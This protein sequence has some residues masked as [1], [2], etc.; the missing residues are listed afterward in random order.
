MKDRKYRREIEV[1]ER[2]SERESI[3]TSGRVETSVNGN[4]CG[5]DGQKIE[6]KGQDWVGLHAGAVS[7]F[8]LRNQ[9]MFL[10]ESYDDMSLS[11]YGMQ[12]TVLATYDDISLGEH[13]VS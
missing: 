5:V 7:A 8:A 4:E 10:L 3:K 1:K 13:R 12:T 6:N 11:F 2:K 9:G